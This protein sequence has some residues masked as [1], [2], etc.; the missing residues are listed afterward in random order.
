MPR[1][2]SWSFGVH[3]EAVL[4]ADELVEFLRPEQPG[5]PE[6]LVDERGLAVVN[7]GDDGDVPDVVPLHIGTVRFSAR[8]TGSRNRQLIFY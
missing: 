7:V 8:S 6:H 2:R 4:A 5:L 1:S 3:D